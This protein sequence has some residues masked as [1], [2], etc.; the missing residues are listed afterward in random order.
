[1]ID[2][3]LPIVVEKKHWSVFLNSLNVVFLFAF[4]VL[5]LIV[6]AK[7]F[8][9]VYSIEFFSGVSVLSVAFTWLMSLF[10]YYGKK[11]YEIIG[12]VKFNEFS[13]QTKI[14][15]EQL[16]Y[17]VM[18]HEFILYY[19]GVRNKGTKDDGETVACRGI[20]ELKI[21]KD[22]SIKFLLSD[23]QEANR[24]KNC[25]KSYYANYVLIDEYT[26]YEGNHRMVELS[27]DFNWTE[28]K[29]T[30]AKKQNRKKEIKD[31]KKS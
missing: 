28:F 15:G 11:D 12:S 9:I 10:K 13:I 7:F 27:G 8:K 23:F 30:E 24:L 14:N 20:S 4:F 17:D 6:L 2:V 18:Q 3:E 19:D 29:N 5:I 1:M 25:I 31:A 22:T 26:R 21:N 16:N